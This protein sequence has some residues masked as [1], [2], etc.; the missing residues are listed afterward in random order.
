[1]N[2]IVSTYQDSDD[3]AHPFDSPNYFE[4][5]Y[6]DAIFDNG[7]SCALSCFWRTRY[8][9]TYIP[10]IIIDIYPPQGEHIRGSAGFDYNNCHASQEKCDVKWGDNYIV[11]EGDTY[12]VHLRAENTG[13]DLTYKRQLPGWRWSDD[14][15]L[16][17]NED[18]KQFWVN[19]LPRADVT[20]SLTIGDKTMPVK[21]EGYHD[22]NWGNVEM[23]QCFAGWGWGRM[24]GPKYTFIYGWTMPL[25]KEIPQTSSLFVARDREIV[26]VSPWVKFTLGNEQVHEESGIQLPN[27]L[28]MKACYE[29]IDINCRLDIVKILEYMKSDP[30]HGGFTTNYFRRQNKY[31]A[32]IKIGDSIDDVSGQALNEYV[33]LR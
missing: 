12:K 24:F 1:M 14:C 21:G 22:H 6:L 3:A 2:K 17:A 13:V 8:E 9:D 16:S 31:D 4:W 15:L 33:L 26:F 23:S 10:L 29:D 25:S 5:W 7:Y 28:S 27:T 20:G 11:Q 32:R 18:G 30:D 19:A